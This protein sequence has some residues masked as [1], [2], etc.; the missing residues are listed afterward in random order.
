MFFFVKKDGNTFAIPSKSSGTFVG[1]LLSVLTSFHSTCPEELLDII[2]FRR[3]VNETLN[4]SS[5]SQETPAFVGKF[6]AV[7]SKTLVALP[8]QEDI[9]EVTF[10]NHFFSFRLFFDNFN[11]F[12]PLVSVETFIG[13]IITW[14][15]L[16]LHL[17]SRVW[18]SDPHFTSREA[19][20]DLW[21][22]FLVSSFT[23]C[24]FL[25]HFC[26]LYLL[27]GRNWTI[28]PFVFWLIWSY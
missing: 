15:I 9:L 17:P 10:F 20:K 25:C 6:H 27:M 1:K 26:V 13:Y 28:L 14:E 2:S 5:V 23:D 22:L 11:E 3:K 19:T 7:L 12:S 18:V 8:L 16:E 4:F 21:E 24:P